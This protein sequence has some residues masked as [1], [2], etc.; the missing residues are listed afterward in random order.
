MEKGDIVIIRDISYSRQV[1]Q[2]QLKRTKYSLKK[3]TKFIIVETNCEFPNP[4]CWQ[5]QSK[6]YNDTVIQAVDG[7]EIVFIEERFLEFDTHKITIDDKTIEI[8]NESYKALKQSL[9]A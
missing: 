3:G 1:I 8:S 7:E 6:R 5:A 4:Y 2:G 9:E